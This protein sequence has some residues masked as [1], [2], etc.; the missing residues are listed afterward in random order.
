MTNR[1][2]DVYAYRGGVSLSRARVLV[3][4]SIIV[5]I[6]HQ[7]SVDAFS[8]LGD[9][10]RLAND[11]ITQGNFYQP[12]CRFNS[13]VVIPTDKKLVLRGFLDGLFGGGEDEKD[14]QNAVLA[15]IDISDVDGQDINTRFESL[16]DF[17]TNKWI[18][19]F[20]SGD[21]KLTTPV[22]VSKIGT[23]AEIDPNAESG[24]TEHIVDSEGCRLVFQ[25]VDTG[26]NSKKEE[27]STSSTKKKQKPKQGGVEVLVQKI[28]STNVEQSF[29]RIVARR[30]E[31]DEDT[32]IK[33]MSEEII[34]NELRKAIDVWN[35]E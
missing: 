15:S 10:R 1:Q 22:K 33:E 30:C 28:S 2:T 25:K 5:A 16:S 18:G 23:A 34:M 4:F 9:R 20:A 31:V 35:R 29:L 14:R 32:M 24:G 26:Y 8:M 27:K 7:S 12:A 17:I 3:L 13:L 11:R 6:C 21:I 19:L